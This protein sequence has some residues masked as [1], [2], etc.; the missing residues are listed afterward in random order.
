MED[1]Y[2]AEH[3]A[4]ELVYAVAGKYLVDAGRLVSF[5]DTFLRLGGLSEI[6][7]LHL[8]LF[9]YGKDGG[10]GIQ[11]IHKF[12]QE[13]EAAFLAVSLGF[14]S[15]IVFGEEYLFVVVVTVEVVGFRVVG[16]TR[17]NDP[18]HEFHGRVVPPAI[19]F[20]LGFHGDFVQRNVG[21]GHRDVQAD[22]P[23]L[24]GKVDFT[25]MITHV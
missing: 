22:A 20:P 4:Q 14:E 10:A 16:I 19:P 24:G 23:P 25:R 15:I 12:L 13:V 2:L 5:H 17:L 1:V 18:A 3:F 11:R 8:L 7:G 21:I 9:R 6:Y